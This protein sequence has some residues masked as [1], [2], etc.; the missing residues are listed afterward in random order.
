MKKKLLIIYKWIILSIVFQLLVLG[1]AEVYFSVPNDLKVQLT[2]LSVRTD[3]TSIP[4]PKNSK[5]IKVSF[6][7]S[8]AAYLKNND[9]EIINLKNKKVKKVIQAGED[10]L[11][12]FRWLPDRNM[13][14]YAVKHKLSNVCNIQ[15]FTYDTE[16]ESKKHF[17]KVS[18]STS[19][20]PEVTDIGLS[21]LTNVVYAKIKTTSTSANIYRFNIM[22]NM[23]KVISVSADASIEET[24]YSDNL[25]FERNYKVFVINGE[26]GNLY[27]LAF[28]EKVCLLRVSFNDNVYIGKL[29]DNNKVNEIIYGRINEPIKKWKMI[30]LKH[31][32]EVKNIFISNKNI[33]YEINQPSYTIYDLVNNKEYSYKGEF[34][35][36]VD[37]NLVTLVEN[38]IKIENLN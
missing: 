25:L 5:N 35:D 13:L 16:S 7:A 23:K 18:L 8:Y 17:S 36:L 6:D 1:G 3:K 2:T 33:I 12:Y 38:S 27:S 32:I 10:S 21:P 11:N 22:G 34:I 4:L 20:N 26:K 9:I 30:S 37:E 31:N 15:L 14:V 29:D 24:M 19:Y 28:K